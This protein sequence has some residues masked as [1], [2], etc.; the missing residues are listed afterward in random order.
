MP[1]TLVAGSSIPY[2]FTL[3]ETVKLSGL[4]PSTIS[5][6]EK[7]G[8]FPQRQQLSTRRIGFRSDQILLW[9]E[10]KWNTSVSPSPNKKGGKV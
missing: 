9:I 6:R 8:M 5:R 7:E 3:K 4:S 10:G 1:S 2:F